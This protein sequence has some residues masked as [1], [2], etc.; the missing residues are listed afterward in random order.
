MHEQYIP[1]RSDDKDYFSEGQY[2]YEVLVY[3]DGKYQYTHELSE[4]IKLFVDGKEWTIDEKMSNGS[5]RYF[6]SPVFTIGDEPIDPNP[7]PNPEEPKGTWKTKWGA[8]YYETEDGRLTKSTW[9]T[10][11][12]DKYYTKSD[13]KLAKSETILKWGKRYTFDENGVLVK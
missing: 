9:I 5:G 1:V 7:D 11:G 12:I 13:G 2:R 6:L 3:I 10:V 8:T 4:E